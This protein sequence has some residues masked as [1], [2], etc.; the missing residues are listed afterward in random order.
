MINSLFMMRVSFVNNYE[1]QDKSLLKLCT[2]DKLFV[3]I[4]YLCPLY[5]K[6]LFNHFTG[7]KK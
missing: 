1:S 5:L 4:N 2:P 3:I 7:P 6:F